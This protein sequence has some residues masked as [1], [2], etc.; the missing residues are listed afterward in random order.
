MRQNL[1]SVKV[2]TLYSRKTI[3]L[4]VIANTLSR[5]EDKVNNID[6][7]NLRFVEDWITILD[8]HRV[9]RLP[10]KSAVLIK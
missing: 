9:K 1:W 8:V 7:P 2:H 6:R 4:Y 3:R 10:S 5:L